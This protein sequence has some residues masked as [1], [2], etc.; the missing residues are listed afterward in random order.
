M[1]HFRNADKKS[2]R[3]LITEK[4][5]KKLVKFSVKLL[6]IYKTDQ[7]LEIQICKFRLLESAECDIFQWPQHIYQNIE[8]KIA[9]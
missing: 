1:A 7:Y 4:M 2:D 6:L 5:D 9:S 8:V 3:I